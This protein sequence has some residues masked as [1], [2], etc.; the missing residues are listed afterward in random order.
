MVILKLKIQSAV[1][2]N[3]GFILGT[4]TQLKPT[5]LNTTTK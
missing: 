1:V 5:G 4:N 3:I 2:Y